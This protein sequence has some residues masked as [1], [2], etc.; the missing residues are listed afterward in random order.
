MYTEQLKEG[1]TYQK[2]K[3]CIHVSL[4]NFIHFPEDTD[5]HHEIAF[6]DL[7]THKKYTD[8]FEIHVLEL[9]K[10]P[11]EQPDEP[12][13]IQWMRFFSAT[14]K[15]EFE[16]MAKKD[17]YI[18]D[19]YNALQKISAD[20]LK[21]LEY[22]ARQKA[23]LDH[24]SQVTGYFEAGLEQGIEQGLEQGLERGESRHNQLTKLLLEAGRLND[25]EKS[26]SDETYR[27]KLYHEFH[28]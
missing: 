26:L 16:K 12:L 4:L 24:N 15:E 1:D 13:L 27:Q 21:R 18:N 20:D 10:L 25:L 19:A 6:C 7:K 9:K 3:K 11:P 22:E 8:L 17:S 2:L 28:L 23:L 14:R 5:C